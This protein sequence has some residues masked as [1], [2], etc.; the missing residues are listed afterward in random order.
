MR[1]LVTTGIILGRI[2]Y[3]EA[4]RILTVLTPQ[5]GK[6]HLIAKGVRRPKSRMAGGVELFSTSQLTYL[7]GRS[8]L[9]T[10]VSSRLDT[11]YSNI[12][13]D[14]ERVQ[15]GYELIKQLNKATEDN[16][17]PEYY[18]LLQMG[19]ASLNNDRIDLELLKLWW[20]AQLLRLSGH[21]PNLSTDTQGNKLAADQMY[22]FDVDDVAFA[23]GPNGHFSS[24]H[25]KTLR[26]FFDGHA[27]LKLQQ[28]TGL[29]QTLPDLAPLLRTMLETYIRL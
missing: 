26:L 19:F 2:N 9:G 18:D 29:S 6:L 10:L 21:G 22:T 28:V 14:I 27:P 24:G 12:V 25:I 13:K 1:Q 8:G 7:A 3:G 20:Y 5:Q 23:L 11:Y 17:E 15:L 16:P 4:D